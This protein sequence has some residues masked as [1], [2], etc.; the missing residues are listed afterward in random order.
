MRLL[1]LLM[2]KILRF[3]VIFVSWLD[4]RNG[5]SFV[6]GIVVHHLVYAK[7]VVIFV[8]FC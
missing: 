7:S 3:F 8:F 5:V 2:P 4:V 1:A 6:V